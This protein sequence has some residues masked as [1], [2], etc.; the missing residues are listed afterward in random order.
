MRE[1]DRRAVLRW[2]ALA[3]AGSAVTVL[4][5]CAGDPNSVE[6]QARTGDRKGYVAGDGSIEQLA[7]SDR[8]EPV[9]LSGTTLEGKPWSLAD[10]DGSV[11][12]V[13]VW[14]SWCPP[15]IEETPALEKAWQKVQA[16]GK[17]VVFIG[18]DKLE[19]A[20]TG[21]AFLTANKVTYPSLAYDGGVPILSL[22]GKAS[23]TPTTLVLDAQGRIAARVSGPITTSTLLGLVDD[24]INEK[25]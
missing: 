10:R 21:L 24:A 25:A 17:K 16:E 6:E 19:S 9:T 2:G 15:C 8:G 20:E 4:A 18:L 23:A 1:P 5:A 13:N 11:V 3:A 22:Q 14:G 7:V 12:V